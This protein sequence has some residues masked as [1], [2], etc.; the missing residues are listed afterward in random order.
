MFEGMGTWV[1]ILFLILP[2]IISIILARIYG[3]SYFEW[4]MWVLILGPLALPIQFWRG[5]RRAGS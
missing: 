4:L 1:F 3:Q 5:Y 2:G